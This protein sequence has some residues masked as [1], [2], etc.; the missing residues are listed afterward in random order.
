VVVVYLTP[1]ALGTKSG[2]FEFE[3]VGKRV[4]LAAG[5]TQVAGN[6][7]HENSSVV[8]RRLKKRAIDVLVTYMKSRRTKRECLV[9][10]A[11]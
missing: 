7:F 4:R 2:V 5:I 3:V 9:V 8:N 11:Y 6:E 10:T 1:N